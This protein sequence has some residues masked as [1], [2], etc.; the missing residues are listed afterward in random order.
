MIR[1]L[2]WLK[3]RRISDR[4]SFSAYLESKDYGLRHRVM[5]RY[6]WRINLESPAPGPLAPDALARNLLR[7]EL[8][9]VAR[10]YP[11]LQSAAAEDAMNSVLNHELWDHEKRIRVEGRVRIRV[12]KPIRKEALQ[13]IEGEMALRSAHARETVE[14]SLLLDRLTDPALG[15]VWWVSRYADLQFA[16]G[17]PKE[18]VK[19]VLCAFKQLQETLH[20]AKIDQTADEKLLVRQKIEEVFS[21]VE[22]EE[23]LS[24][25]LQVMNRTLDHL[26]VNGS[27]RS[28]QNGPS[29][30]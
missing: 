21:V 27:G 12:S 15:P 9:S 2:D 17:D 3:E 7:E 10:T 30:V 22:D 14:L 16:A 19:S 18:K 20:A 4:R 26:G 6:R 5:I 28:A 24:L 23:S 25:A 1:I 11:L 8:G 13:R 29:P